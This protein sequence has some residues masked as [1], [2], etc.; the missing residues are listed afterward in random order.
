MLTAAIAA[1]GFNPLFAQNNQANKT[2]QVKSTPVANTQATPAATTAK[3]DTKHHERD[4][5][6]AH[7]DA[8]NKKSTA[9]HHAHH[10]VQKAAAPAP[11]K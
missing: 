2:S 3:N 6:T 1:L 11:Q 7:H 4:S 9:K 5:K 10:D 8:M